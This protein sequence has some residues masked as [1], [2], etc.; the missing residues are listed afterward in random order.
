V[1][2]AYHVFFQKVADGPSYQVNHS[3]ITY[4]MSP[5][6]DFVCV[7]P[8]GETPQAMADQVLAA[9]KQGPHAT[10]CRA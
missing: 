2:G 4:L 8:Y 7:I 5:T 1:A 9:M 6:G 3:T 10:S